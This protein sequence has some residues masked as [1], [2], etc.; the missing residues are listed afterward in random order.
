VKVIEI[1][2]RWNRI[3]PVLVSVAAVALSAETSAA[4]IAGGPGRRYGEGAEDRSASLMSIPQRRAFLRRRFIQR[5]ERSPK[6]ALTEILK[7]A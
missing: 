7:C 4:D 2:T 3:I 5:A 1:S 6:V